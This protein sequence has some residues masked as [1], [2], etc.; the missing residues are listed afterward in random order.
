[1]YLFYLYL[2]VTE[3]LF[4]IV[5]INNIKITHIINIFLFLI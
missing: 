5:Q 4:N 1:M 2:G 3:M